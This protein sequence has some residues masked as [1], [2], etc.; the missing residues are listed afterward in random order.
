[1]NGCFICQGLGPNAKKP[2][3]HNDNDSDNDVNEKLWMFQTD[4][5]TPGKPWFF[6]PDEVAP[7]LNTLLDPNCPD[8]GHEIWLPTNMFNNT[9]HNFDVLQPQKQKKW[10]L[11][12][13]LTRTN[14]RTAV[15]QV[16]DQNLRKRGFQLMAK[17]RW[18]DSRA[19]WGV[20]VVID[21]C[22]FNFIQNLVQIETL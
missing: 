22:K 16:A 1:M 13:N 17:F 20:Q 2:K 11:V 3:N 10:V 8:E 21:N 12:E 15:L 7:K 18:Q 9:H 6:A 5:A 14:H 19:N 4:P